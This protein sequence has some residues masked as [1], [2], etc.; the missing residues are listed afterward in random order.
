MIGL[1]WDD[2]IASDLAGY[3]VYTSTAPG[4]PFNLHATVTITEFLDLSVTNTIA[5]YYQVSAYDNGSNESG[6]SNIASATPY[7]LAPYTNTT[8]VSC[9]GTVPNCSDAGGPKD[10]NIISLDPGE[11]VTLDF[12][13][14]YG[15]MDGPGPDMVFYE[16]PF[17]IG[18]RLD[19]VTIDVSEDGTNWYTVFN[20]D[21][22]AGGVSGTNIDA[23]AID[24][25]GEEE[26]EDIDSSELY[27]GTGITID[28]GIWTPG[29]YSFRYVRLSD[30]GGTERSEIDA[31][32]RLN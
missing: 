20:W 27:N 22:I 7:S 19:F 2:V 10:D 30:A 17:G 16:N 13:A 18:I 9:T 25:S 32:E 1:G 5:Y 4:G 6:P 21:G 23:H 3:R 15:I 14:G 29:G 28:I 8:T 11:S 31:V 26:N 24:G 12:G